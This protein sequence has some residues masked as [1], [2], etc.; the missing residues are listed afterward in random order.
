MEVA[1]EFGV[2]RDTIS[3]SLRLVVMATDLDSQIRGWDANLNQAK[4]ETAKKLEELEGA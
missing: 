1:I 2:C 4:V 3:Y